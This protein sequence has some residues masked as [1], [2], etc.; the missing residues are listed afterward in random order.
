M[1]KLGYILH[2][3]CID[4]FLI[5]INECFSTVQLKYPNLVLFIF[6]RRLLCL[7]RCLHETF[8]AV[9][10]AMLIFPF[11]F[12]TIQLIRIELVSPANQRFKEQL[13]GRRHRAVISNFYNSI[14]NRFGRNPLKNG[15]LEIINLF[16]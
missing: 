15:S 11:D 8:R 12:L 13:D 4:I 5:P 9:S 7:K 16:F 14:R 1:L 2:Y 3:R 6:T 10:F